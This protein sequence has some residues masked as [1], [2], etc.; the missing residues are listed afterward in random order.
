[1]ARIPGSFNSKLAKL[2]EKGEIVNI[3][4]SAEV[5]IIKKWNGVRP[6]IK[7]LL[8]DFYIYLEDSEIKEIHINRKP[9]GSM[10]YA[11]YGKNNKIRW[12]ET[13]L[14]NLIS[15]HRKYALWRI[16]APY[17]INIKKLSYE[18]ALGIIRD[19]LDKCDHA[20]V[21]FCS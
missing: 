13:L 20:C 11:N 4:E 17:L 8:A 9:G 14:Q 21:Y 19:W 16:V 10:R 7:P 12:I 2:N 1:M 5:K 6:S 3:P 18:D 15:D